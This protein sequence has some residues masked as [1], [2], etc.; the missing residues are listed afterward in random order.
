MS[1]LTIADGAGG[2]VVLSPQAVAG[3]AVL[4]LPTGTANL[5]TTTLTAGNTTTAALKFTGGSSL[6]TAAAGSLEYDG[7][8]FYNTGQAS[9]RG[10]LPTPQVYWLNT[11]ITGGNDATVRSIFGAGVTLSA[12]TSYMMDGLIWLT[13]AAGTTSHV[14]ALSFTGTATLNSILYQAGVAYSIAPVVYDNGSQSQTVSNI[15]TT[16]NVTSAITTTTS[17]PIMLRGSVTTNAGGTFIPSYAANRA[18]GGAYTVNSGSY[19]TFTPVGT[20]GNLAI[21]PWA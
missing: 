7:T 2:N 14:L 20:T 8:V 13:R 21:G 9:E 12:N 4:T 1:S 10:V 5:L 18:P 17:T 19:I 3:T 15:A 16:Q 6:S 11:S